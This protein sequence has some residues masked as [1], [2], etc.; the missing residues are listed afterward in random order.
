MKLFLLPQFDFPVWPDTGATITVIS[1]D[2]AKANSLVVKQTKHKRLLAADDSVLNVLGS[3]RFKIRG[4]MIKALVSK[5]LSSEILLGW[6][7][8]V[9]LSIIPES[10]PEPH[11][12][13][14]QANV[15]DTDAIDCED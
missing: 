9:R 11:H 7:D 6:R 13:F 1:G 14:H 5:S 3:T 10:F 8:M 2:L 12:C 15:V 4:V